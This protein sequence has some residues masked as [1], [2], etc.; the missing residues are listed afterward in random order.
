MSTDCDVGM[1]AL[2]LGFVA[3]QQEVILL[4]EPPSGVRGDCGDRDAIIAANVSAMIDVDSES[5]KGA[6][7]NNS[8][9]MRG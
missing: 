6:V 2:C 8:Q 4:R 1:L 9:T 5:S 3:M 7:A